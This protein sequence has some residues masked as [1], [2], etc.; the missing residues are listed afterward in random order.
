M[1]L[2]ILSTA[3]AS[4]SLSIRNLGR[5]VVFSAEKHLDIYCCLAFLSAKSLFLDMSRNVTG[6]KANNFYLKRRRQKLS[7]LAATWWWCCSAAPSLANR[8][9][10]CSSSRRWV[11]IGW[12]D[13]LLW[14]LL[15]RLR[16]SQLG[17]M[18]KIQ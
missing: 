18:I 15:L 4:P 11:N 2:G 6:R 17:D 5:L 3:A 12:T 16:N 8:A 7:W 1:Y 10:T 9:T 14:Q 13:T